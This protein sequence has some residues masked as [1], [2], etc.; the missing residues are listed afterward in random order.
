MMNATVFSSLLN[1]AIFLVHNGLF[2]KMAYT[3]KTQSYHTYD[4][5]NSELEKHDTYI[6]VTSSDTAVGG[7]LHG[8]DGLAITAAGV[9]AR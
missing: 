2:D 6:A 4:A 3:I 1:V 7:S 5:V 9:L 8:T